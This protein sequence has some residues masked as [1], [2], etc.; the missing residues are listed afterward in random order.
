VAGR[1]KGK[2]RERIREKEMREREGE[3]ERCKKR[4]IKSS[5]FNYHSHL[6]QDHNKCALKFPHSIPT[7]HHI[8][9]TMLFPYFQLFKHDKHLIPRL[10]IDVLNFG[11]Y[12][13]M[14][15]Y[16][17]VYL[18]SLGLHARVVYITFSNIIYFNPHSHEW[19]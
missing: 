19:Y 7:I 13:F 1:K 9:T 14:Y 3:R 12:T 16:F 17:I 6:P 10:C 8:H 5:L 18:Y 15:K 11:M 2:G 4:Y